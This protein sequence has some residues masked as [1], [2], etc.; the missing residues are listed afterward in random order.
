MNA[1]TVTVTVAPGGA[2]RFDP[3]T[4]NIQA[5]DTVKW[6]WQD[7]FHSATSDTSGI[8]DSG[9][10]NNGAEFSFTFTNPG[11]VPYHC[12]P[13][14]SCCGMVGTVNVAATP[15]PTPTPTPTA[16]PTPTS[17]PT[18]T[19]TPTPTSTPTPT[20]TVTPSPTATPTS[21]PTPT[22]TPTPTVSPTATPTP[23]PTPGAS[24]F[25]VST[26]A[27]VGSGDQVLIG[28]I[29]INAD[30][31]NGP[32][33]MSPTAGKRVLLRA[34]GPSLVPFGITN[35]LP[36]PVLELHASDGSL[37]TTNDNWVDSLDKAQI[38]ATGLQPTNDL[39]PAI[40]TTLDPNAYTAIVTGAGGA[41]GVALVEAYDLDNGGGGTQLANISTR[42]FV[43]TDEN[44]MIGGFILGPDD[45]QNAQILVRAIGPSLTQFGVTDALLD[46]TLELHDAN[47]TLMSNNDWQDTQA[48]EIGATGLAPTDPKES[49]ILMSLPPGSYTAIVSGNNGQ[50]G[51]ALVEVY[52]TQASV[53]NATKAR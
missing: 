1:A 22:A 14:G 35:A 51:V 18:P 8:F 19:T 29:I 27:M 16:T 5:G 13:H 23:T 31:G 34:I 4:V 36:D 12:T 15:T 17:T 11:S 3:D 24:S 32:S 7:D 39:E 43:G 42:G 47:G 6:V 38:E 30:A 44:V 25:N 50:T 40:I 37:I 48:A 33:L 52:H 46:P 28:G 9:I 10:L 20:A 53:T 21:T 26:R 41:T 49:A 2:F 45:A